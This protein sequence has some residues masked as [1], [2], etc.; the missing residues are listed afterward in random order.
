MKKILSLLLISYILIFAGCPPDDPDPQPT[1]EPWTEK[2]KLLASDGAADDG[3]GFSSQIDGDYLIIGAP[4]SDSG[5]AYIFYNDGTEWIEQ[6]K[7]IASDE[8]SGEQFGWSV[9]ISGDYAI[10]GAQFDDDNGNNSGSAY[11]FYRNGTEWIEQEK[12][13]GSVSNYR[14]G[15]SAGIYGDYAIVGTFGAE[16]AYIYIRNGSTW[17]E[18]QSLTASDGEA[19]DYFGIGVDIFSDYAVVGANRDS[20]NGTASGSAYIFL[21]TDTTWN[22][23]GKLIP[24]DGQDDDRFGSHVDIFNNYVTA[25]AWGVDDNGEESGAFYIFS[26]EGTTWTELQKITASDGDA[27][28]RF[29]RGV[30]ISDEYIIAGALYDAAPDSESGSA[31]IFNWDGSECPELQKITASDGDSGDTF[32]NSVSISGNTILVGAIFDDDNGQNSGSAY[33]FTKE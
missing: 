1:P 8:V 11:I 12:F 21:R 30:S 2:Q 7:L 6:D 26:R 15:Y 4:Y 29:G 19:G 5:S 10:I 14:F 3:F 33:I 24:G 20:D 27:Y 23:Q 22:E 16:A 9:G 17:T 13:L 31:Y 25:Y 28:D 32:G 18:Q